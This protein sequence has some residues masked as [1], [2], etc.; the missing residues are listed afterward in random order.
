M[1]DYSSALFLALIREALAR[2][3]VA[4]PAPT[5]GGPRAMTASLADKRAVIEQVLAAYGPSPLLGIGVA[6]DAFVETPLAVVLGS[7]P[8]PFDLVARWRRLERY[9]HSR[10]RTRVV[11]V[12]PNAIGIEHFARTG[13]P[14]GKAEDLVVAAVLAALVGWLGGCGI[15]LD[16][17]DGERVW[18]ALR[19]GRPL[20]FGPGPPPVATSV[21]RVSWAD[22]VPKAVK[23]GPDA[24]ELRWVSTG[25]KLA[26]RHVRKV[27]QSVLADP[28]RPYSLAECACGLGLSRR[29]LQRRLGDAGAGFKDIVAL[30][31]LESAARALVETAAPMA[32]IGFMAGYT[33]QAHFSREFRKGTGMSPT[34]F[35]ELAGQ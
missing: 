19:D 4:V 14:P 2:Q 28:M 32:A 23:P 13:P 35:R 20:D 26:D 16:F 33:D 24:T 12:R 9:Y 3:G 17:L 10:H 7:A 22:F 18:P 29:T 21:W 15:D 27:F 6:L 5:G 25:F 30:A 1:S 31:R 34:E 11:A 8:T